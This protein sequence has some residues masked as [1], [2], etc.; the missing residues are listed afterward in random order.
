MH[1]WLQAVGK[2]SALTLYFGREKMCAGGKRCRRF[3]ES[4]FEARQCRGVDNFICWQ[5][6]PQ[7]SLFV[8]R[9]VDVFCHAVRVPCM[10]L[11]QNVLRTVL[12][13]KGMVHLLTL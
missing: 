8:L 11:A 5:L 10:Q 7:T 4:A 12:P 2:M 1:A 9:S 3:V 6:D 13:I